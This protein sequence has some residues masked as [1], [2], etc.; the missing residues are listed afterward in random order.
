MLDYDGTLAPFR[1]QRDK[2]FPYPGVR[3]LLQAVMRQGRSRVV[4]VSGRSVKDVLPLLGI[5]PAPEIW[6]SHGLE[7]RF[8]N[9]HYQMASLDAEGGRG[10]ANA[11]EWVARQGLESRC[12]TKPGSVALHWRGMDPEE[13]REVEQAGLRGWT[14]IARKFNLK[15]HPFDGGLELRI[16]GRNKGDAVRTLL[17]ESSPDVAA[18]YLGDDWTD[19]DAFRILEGK[20]LGVLVRMEP[21]ESHADF[22]IRPP[23]Q[24]LGFL[25][26]W[27][28]G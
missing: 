3:N 27:S 5:D 13:K 9:G 17:G 22:W 25:K 7:R 12:E 26:T 2:A 10:L 21:R 1:E 19:E 18:A 6:G 23:E 28:L 4:V 15:I 11:D 16:P 20:G 24:L 8:M 14:P